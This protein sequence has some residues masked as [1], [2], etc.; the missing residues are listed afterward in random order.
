MAIAEKILNTA[1]TELTVRVPEAGSIVAKIADAVED[2]AEAAAKG[3]QDVS[4]MIPGVGNLAPVLATIADVAEQVEAA[5]ESKP[6]TDSAP[7]ASEPLPSSPELTPVPE[8]PKSQGEASS[9]PP[10]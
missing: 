2:V 5:V 7:L 3:V 10:Q 1:V 6:G 4:G 8:E 9:E